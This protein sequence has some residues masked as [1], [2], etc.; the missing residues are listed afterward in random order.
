MTDGEWRFAPVDSAPKISSSDAV[1]LHGDA[2]ELIARVP[3]HSVD[4]IFTDPPY[5]HS[6]CVEYCRWMAEQCL[7]VVKPGGSLVTLIGHT[8]L[9]DVCA[10]FSQVPQWKFR[11]PLCMS[12]LEGRHAQ[13]RMAGVEVLWK[14]ALWYSNGLI[15]AQRRHDMNLFR[16]A[17]E[18]PAN[19]AGARK[20][21]H[22]WQQS[23]EWSDYYINAL[24]FPGE[25]VLD[26]FCGVGTFVLSALD[27]GR[28][29]IGFDNDCSAVEATRDAIGDVCLGDG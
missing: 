7:R 8:T 5:K 3:D 1:V 6:L 27:I 2:R 28:R 9:P 29:A 26:P 20:R 19:G 10:A 14:P 12:Q 16:D 23:R 17:V 15:P 4:L 11:W 18:M 25:T 13:M 24:T 21:E 22:E